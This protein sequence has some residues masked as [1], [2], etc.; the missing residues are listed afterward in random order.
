MNTFQCCRIINTRYKIIFQCQMSKSQR[1]KSEGLKNRWTLPVLFYQLLRRA[2]HQSAQ[3]FSPSQRADAYAVYFIFPFHKVLTHR[4]EHL[5]GL[6][7]NTSVLIHHK[8][9]DLWYSVHEE[10]KC[11]KQ[12]KALRKRFSCSRLQ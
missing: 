8:G 6:R 2:V 10:T 7:E 5:C 9:L 4:L 12:A 11:C 3:S 1:C